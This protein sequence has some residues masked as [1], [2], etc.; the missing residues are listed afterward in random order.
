M[1]IEMKKIVLYI[2]IFTAI[3]SCEEGSLLPIENK[4]GNP[5][6]VSGIEIN[7]IAGGAIITYKLPDNPDLLY[8]KASYTLDNGKNIVTKSSIYNNSL[9]IKG[10]YSEDETKTYDIN[11]VSVDRS[12]N[13][14][15]PVVAKIQPELSPLQKVKNSFKFYEAFGGVQ[16]TWENK[17]EE[18][19]T[20]FFMADTIMAQGS[21]PGEL[22]ITKILS[23]SIVEGKYVDRGYP[24]A[25]RKFAVYMQDVYGNK[26]EIITPSMDLTPL[27]EEKLDKSKMRVLEFE[28]TPVEDNWNFWNSDHQNLI[29]NDRGWSSVVISYQSPYP[30]HITIDLGATY[31]VS[32]YVWWQQAGEVEQGRLAEYAYTRGNPNK[33]Y[34]YV[35]NEEIEP[36]QEITVDNDGDGLPDWTNHWIKVG[37]HELVKPSGLPAGQ[38][39]E[40]DIDA[41]INTGHNFDLPLE[42]DRFRYIRYGI[43]S[44][45]DG[46]G[47]CNMAEIDFYGS[48]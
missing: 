37:E 26:T 44:N 2:I 25:P 4:A 19:I 22:T 48:N 18:P 29:D 47:W 17:D 35:R 34:I 33:W 38:L 45:F 40:E 32:R 36:T 43:T 3:I 39:S 6:Q 13:E 27:F 42:V 1:Y 30:R 5:A 20:F 16:Y 23:S 11:I 7:N 8:V 31:K 41:I 10:F 46:A 24:S 15:T 14:S 21:E 12:N 28:E 9:T